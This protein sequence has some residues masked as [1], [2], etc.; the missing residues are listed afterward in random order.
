MWILILIFGLITPRLTIALLYL[1]TTWFNGVFETRAWP[2]LGFL[3]MPL[4]L[5]WYSVV[6]KMMAGEWNWWQVLITVLLVLA[7]LGI[8]GRSSK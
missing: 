6:E 3:F 1:F 2:I 4:T 7:D 8:I 5:L